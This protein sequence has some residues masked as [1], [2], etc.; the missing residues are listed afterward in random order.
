[1]I[2][3]SFN[4]KKKVGKPYYASDARHV[5]YPKFRLRDAPVLVNIGGVRQ[6]VSKFLQVVYTKSLGICC[7]FASIL[8][9]SFGFHNFGEDMPLLW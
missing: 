7:G 8:N 1:M 5:V 6:D 9:L 3:N 2:C 4:N